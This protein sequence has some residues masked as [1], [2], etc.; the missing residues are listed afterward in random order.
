MDR[1]VAGQGEACVLAVSATKPQ[2]G[3][4][5][6][7]DAAFCHLLLPDGSESFVRKSEIADG[8]FRAVKATKVLKA[9]GSWMYFAPGTQH[10]LNMTGT[11][12]YT[13]GGVFV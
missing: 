2:F 9:D 13:R 4:I 11:Q 10:K 8:T 7:T 3:E 12:W 6:Q 5:V 1:R